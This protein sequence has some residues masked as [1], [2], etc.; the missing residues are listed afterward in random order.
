MRPLGSWLGLEG[1]ALAFDEL[2][3]VG[4]FDGREVQEDIVAQ[5]A[6]LR[7]TIRSFVSPAS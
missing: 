6:N 5:A 7:L 4:A 3:V 2:A 1:E